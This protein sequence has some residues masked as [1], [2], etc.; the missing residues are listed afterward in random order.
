MYTV[1]DREFVKL[2]GYIG[3]RR[4]IPLRL[5]IV[6]KIMF[7]VCTSTHY[8]IHR[9]SSSLPPF[10]FQVMSAPIWCGRQCI[11]EEWQINEATHEWIVLLCVPAT[12]RFVGNFTFPV[13][14]L[15]GCLTVWFTKLPTCYVTSNLAHLFI[16]PRFR[17]VVCER[18]SVSLER[19]KCG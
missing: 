15:D 17:G 1:H 4:Y 12:M 3:R 10:V 7:F 13:P 9:P 8:T 6:N 11:I 5:F 18:F 2:L 14:S 19:R 16:V